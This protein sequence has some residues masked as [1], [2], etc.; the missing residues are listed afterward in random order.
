MF[1][2]EFFEYKPKSK[3]IAILLNIFFFGSGY[4]YIGNFKKVIL[5]ILSFLFMQIS[6]F[7]F[8]LYYF[9]KY[10]LLLNLII[11]ATIYLYSIYDVIK[12]INNK[13]DKKS[14]WFFIVLY[15]I[16]IYPVL[17]I[18]VFSAPVRHFKLPSASMSP[19]IMKDE[20]FIVLKDKSAPKRGDLIVF[21]YPLD[22]DILFIK[23]CVAVEGDVVFI[24]NK[25]FFLH[26]KEG[27]EFVKQHYLNENIIKEDGKLW[28][29]NP[30]K[31]NHPGIH[32]D[33]S[34][35]QNNAPE[36]LFNMKHIVIQKN[37][38]FILGDNRDHS[39]D[40]RFWGTVPL[41]SIY[42]KPKVIY[43]NFDNYERIG[44]ILK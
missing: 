43:I 25:N 40:S 11:Y 41:K 27:N 36:R 8:A 44:N 22:E 29:K 9:N 3:I 20:S 30:Y 42:G 38:F 31:N 26:P 13:E 1:E 6:F 35:N 28:I 5:F 2:D 39:N 32:I 23:R 16:V 10:I 12:I 21:Q 19:T 18:I 33:S 34:V 4:L 14:N 37:E 15:M 17:Y 7:Y 24:K